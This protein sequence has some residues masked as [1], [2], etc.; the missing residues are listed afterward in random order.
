[1]VRS[2]RLELPR[3]FPHSDLN[4]ARLQ[5]PHRPHAA[6]PPGVGRVLSKY[7]VPYQAR[8]TRGWAME[9]ETG[10]GA[11]EI[12]W[13]RDGVPVPYDRAVEAMERRVAAIRERS[14]ER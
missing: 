1:M 6:A 10:M 5:V 13:R 9:P 4:A 11:D 3:S 8:W 7:A 14:E 2:R 12:E